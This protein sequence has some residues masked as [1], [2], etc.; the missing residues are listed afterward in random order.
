MSGIRGPRPDVASRNRSLENRAKVSSAMKGR[1]KTYRGGPL[2]RPM[3]DRI[4]D[5]SMPVP[6]TGCWLWLGALDRDGYGHI[7]VGRKTNTGA[8]RAAYEAFVGPIPTG[9]V[10]DH[11]CR[12]RCCVNPDHLEPVTPRENVL[13]GDSSAA[14]FAR[15]TH[16]KR[17]HRLVVFVAEDDPSFRIRLCKECQRVSNRLRMRKSRWRR[18]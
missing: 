3:R 8:H 18:A 12:V 11:R 15:R 4:Q 14:E 5:R 17:G 10:I 13:R 6:W 9:M 1:G 7:S 16:C 2:P